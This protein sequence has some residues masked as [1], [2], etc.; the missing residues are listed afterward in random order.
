MIAFNA[1]PSFYQELLSGYDILIFALGSFILVTI[2]LWYYNR[3]SKSNNSNSALEIQLYQSKDFLFG[4]MNQNDGFLTNTKS[5]STFLKV[6]LY[7]LTAIF[8]LT[9]FGDFLGFI[10]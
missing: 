7:F 2:L 6:I 8:I 3:I 4:S 9:P 10:R 5:T 1:T